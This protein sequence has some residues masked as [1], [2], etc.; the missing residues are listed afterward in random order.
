MASD[1]IQPWG[2]APTPLVP[3]PVAKNLGHLDAPPSVKDI[4]GGGAKVADLHGRIW[5]AA[6]SVDRPCLKEIV[7]LLRAKAGAIW[8]LPVY[9]ERLVPNAMEALPFSTRTRNAVAANARAFSRPD[10]RFSDALSAPSVGMASAIEFACVVESAAAAGVSRRG[11]ADGDRRPSAGGEPPALARIHSF[12]HALSSW[13]SGEAGL[14]R[15][16]DAL[17]EPLPEWPEEVRSLW[18]DVGRVEAGALAGAASSRL[19]V[20]RLVAQGIADLGERRLA[21]AEE[22]VFAV[23]NAATLA[24]LGRRF[25]VTRE[26]IRQVEK[27][28]LHRLQR[29]SR[30][31]HL[32]VSRRAE[33]IRDRLGGAAPE[34][35]P[36]IKD[37]LDR[38][39]ED[40]G[41]E[42]SDI[43]GTA[44]ALLLWLAGPYRVDG[45][46]LLRDGGLPEKSLEA[47]LRRRD[48]R[49]LISRESV[50]EALDG[51]G[52]NREHHPPWVERL[53]RFMRVEEGL[54]HMHGHS[55]DKALSL[56][57]Y[58]SRPMSAEELLARTGG[59]SVHGLRQRL[60]EDPRFWKINAQDEF[61]PAGTPGYDEFGG[62]AEMIIKEIK[63][64]GG[65]APH[66]HLV[67]KI[68][69]LRGVR[70]STVISR[71]KTPMFVTED[72]FAR[73][74]DGKDAIA[75]TRT[76]ARPPPAACSGGESGVGGSG[77]TRTAVSESA[78]P[79]G[80]RVR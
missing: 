71:L 67:E 10:L 61:V 74:R 40:F 36:A 48:G 25:R 27:E 59:K 4:L 56:L 77:T 65:R 75:R 57:R 68:S 52:I 80:R 11:A 31:E 3:M 37:A 20:P 12:F 43:R 2:R 19:S 33:S 62:I 30:G 54:I 29:F 51:L 18:S 70:K 79:P 6:D 49:G 78:A 39:V 23:K 16:A 14:A 26:R 69:R 15:L 45:A 76:S 17:P 60:I 50:E 9:P 8:R 66:G 41:G 55:L 64:R 53:G 7:G 46:W 63:A 72:G 58:H 44:R 42:H 1:I 28:T 13:G 32:A 5:S 24:A 34:G 21:V 38:A 47:L 73:V 22:R 35:H